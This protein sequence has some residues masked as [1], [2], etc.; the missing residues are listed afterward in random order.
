MQALSLFQLLIVFI[1]I[2]LLYEEA[3]ILS[4]QVNRNN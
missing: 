1:V 4:L 3:T 2:P